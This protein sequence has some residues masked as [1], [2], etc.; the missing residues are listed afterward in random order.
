MMRF[1]YEMF[2][3]VQSLMLVLPLLVF[4]NF[5]VIGLFSMCLLVINNGKMQRVI[6]LLIHYVMCGYAT[7][8]VLQN[9]AI[10]NSKIIL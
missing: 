6:T 7:M 10:D 1:T 9:I 3:Q 5:S 8:T 4:L 2:S